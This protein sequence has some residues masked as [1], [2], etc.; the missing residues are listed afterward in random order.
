[1]NLYDKYFLLVLATIILTRILVYIFNKPSPTIK[2]FRI[3][4]WMYGLIFTIIIFA[5]AGIYKNVYLLA[6]SMGIFFDEIGFIFIRGK[7]HQDNYSPESFMIILFFILL[8]FLFRE[9]IV[10]FYLNF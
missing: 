3:H 8:L 4:H 9:T 10:D 6:V 2:K 1:M 5:I 7:N